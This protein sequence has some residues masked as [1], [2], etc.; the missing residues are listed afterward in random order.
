[1]SVRSVHDRAELAALL[2]R[3][4]H[5]HA[6]QLG[7]LDDFFWPYTTWYRRDDAV[8]MIYHGGP[9]PTLLALHPEATTSGSAQLNALLPLLPGRFDAH[10]SPGA[11][12]TLTG[13]FTDLPHGPHLKMALTDPARLA[14]ATPAGEVLTRTDL[15]ALDRLYATAYPANAFDPR[16]LDT[17]HYVGL[18]EDGE[19]VAVAGVHVWS[20]TYRVAAL[21]N[22]TTHPDRRGRGLAT[23][24]VAALCRRLRD[25][26]DHLTLNVKVDNPAAR[27]V[28][29]RLGFTVAA[30]YT[31]HTFIARP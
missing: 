29:A 5:L 24:L 2:G 26:V 18:R 1:M 15:P 23:A 31:E 12:A 22:V 19:L 13:R 11:A 30:G 14:A 10:L 28:Y 8:A 21:G 7:D 4:P 16:M 20:P 27:A 9:E 17:G 3:D 25:S 6:Y